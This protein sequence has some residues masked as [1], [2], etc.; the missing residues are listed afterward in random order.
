MSVDVTF[1]IGGKAGQ[2]MQ[3]ISYI[4]GKLFTRAGYYVFVNQDVMSRIRG[5]HNFS[6]IRIKHESV[7]APSQTINVLI[8]L[9]R[10]SIDEHMPELIEDGVIIFDGEKIDFKS[11]NPNFF[12]IPLERLAQ[13]HGKSKVMM[14]TVATGAAI[15]LMDYDLEELFQILEERFKAKGDEVVK[16]NITSAHA[17]YKY[18]QQNFRGICPCKVAPAPVLK[19]KRILIS[20]SEAIAIGAICSGLKFYAGYPMSPSTPIMEFIASKQEEHGI[21]VEQAEDEIAAINMVIGASFAGV[22]S[23]TATSGGGFCLMVEG[24]SL[25]G[26]TETPI[27]IVIGQRPGPATGLPTRTEQADLQFV[28]NA[29]HGEFPRAI[30]APG[31][32]EQAFYLISKAFNLAEKYQT[33]VIVLGDQLLLDSYYT[34]DELDLSKIHIDRGEWLNDEDIRSLGPY[35]YKRYTL[36]E[37]GISPRIFPGQEDAVLYADSDEHTEEGHITE[38]AEVRINMVSKRMKKLEGMRKEMGL[39]EVYPDN[40]WKDLLVGWGSTYGAIK[41]VV[42]ILRAEGVKVAMLHFRDVYPLKVQEIS[43]ILKKA[44]KILVIENNYA[45]QFARLL[46]SET[47]ISATHKILKFDGRPFTPQFLLNSI[48]EKIL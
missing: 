27:V 8:A 19:K 28:L 46:H 32:A 45:G 31:D 40:D 48:R 34:L 10:E 14:N 23:M 17:G 43:N 2:G 11:D 30:L 3:S 38:S 4:M 29:A 16:N 13:E 35:Q 22:R 9:D 41:E 37:T 15:A 24:L 21:V 6:Q 47:G 42:E 36:T 5:G 39:P 44:A 33:P 25:A 1:K 20:G 12:S 7:Y 18:V 26:G